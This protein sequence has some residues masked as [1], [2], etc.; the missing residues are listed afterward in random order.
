MKKDKK[1]QVLMPAKDLDKSLEKIKVENIKELE[2]KKVSKVGSIA[3]KAKE[4]FLKLLKIGLIVLL[5]YN[6]GLFVGKTATVLYNQNAYKEEIVLYNDIVEET[7][8]L[9]SS[10]EITDPT[11]IFSFY[12]ML[13]DQGYFS[14][15][16]FTYDIYN[17]YDV[18][19]SLGIEVVT[20]SG[21]CRHTSELLTDIF[22]KLGYE[23]YSMVNALDDGVNIFGKV[24]ANIFGNHVITIVKYDNK[25][26][27]FD[28][29]NLSV[30]NING[31]DA[32]AVNS[33]ITLRL[34]PITSLE[35]YFLNVEEIINFNIDY[36]TVKDKVTFDEYVEKY[37]SGIE[38]YYFNTEEINESHEK[39]D[40]KILKIN[41]KLKK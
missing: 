39:I 36:P 14:N 23:A 10:L 13:M 9:I 2:D 8:N 11:E 17:N 16:Q 34:M 1:P 7:A 21:A 37:A 26:Y 40:E 29:T 18:G 4:K 15:K 20:G 38:K 22:D 24:H 33:D 31:L 6:G 19:G 28:P 3:L 5:I 41:N 32:K 12:I 30:Y 27:G 25:L 35:S